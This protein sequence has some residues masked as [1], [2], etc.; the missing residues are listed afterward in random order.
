[1]ASSTFRP[2]KFNPEIAF[3][4]LTILVI[5]GLRD[6][7]R[8]YYAQIADRDHLLSALISWSIWIIAGLSLGMILGYIGS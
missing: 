3:W 7:R 4:S 2:K 6:L 1:M 8:A 5:S